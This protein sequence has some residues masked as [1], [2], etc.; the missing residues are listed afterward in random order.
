MDVSNDHPV[1]R[2]NLARLLTILTN[3]KP[4]LPDG[5]WFLNGSAVLYLHGIW[6][7]RPMGDLDVFLATRPW[8]QFPV[9]LNPPHVAYYGGGWELRTPDPT[10]PTCRHD[11]PYWERSLS[12]LPVHVFSAWRVRHIADIDCNF[13]THNAQMVRGWPCAPI[14]MVAAWKEQKLRAK[15]AIDVEAI[16]RRYPE[17][18]P[19]EQTG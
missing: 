17:L 8:T 9:I 13:L 15:D 5:Q 18:R 12:G 11:P 2:E 6:T 14:D 1:F 19:P 16:Y 7:G 4:A 3:I 10:D